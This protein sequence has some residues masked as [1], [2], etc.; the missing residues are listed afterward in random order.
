MAQRKKIPM[1]G[2][3]E[4]QAARLYGKHVSKKKAWILLAV[5][6]IVCAL[7]IIHGV[8][9]WDSIAEIVTTGII[10][11]DGQDDSMP[12]P[13][14]VFG[15][16]GLLCA[17]NLIVHIKLSINQKKSTMPKFFLLMFGRWGFPIFSTIFANIFISRAAGQPP[18]VLLINSYL[19]G[20]ALLLLSSHMLDCQPG[21]PVALRFSFIEKDPCV[22]ETTHRFAAYL[23]MAV[24]L[25]IL[26]FAAV[27]GGSS[28]CFLVAALVAF[29][30]SV[31]YGW[32]RNKRVQEIYSR[33]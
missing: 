11:M 26:T 13:L 18:N 12:R 2:E 25:G 24:G 4:A 1:T 28:I 9:L 16:P 6:M 22:W 14:L 32:I 7:P 21:S 17:L 8:R 20:L 5:T 23:W 27:T 33:N 3:M 15:I 30:A 31:L 10:R 29:S 19:P